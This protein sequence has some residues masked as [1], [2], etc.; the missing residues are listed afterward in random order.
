MTQNSGDSGVDHYVQRMDLGA[1]PFN[2]SNDYVYAGAGRSQT[3][4]QLIHFVRFGEQVV[5]LL[6]ATGSGTSTLLDQS[7][8]TLEDLMDCCFINGDDE[9]SPDQVMASL[10]EQ[11]QLR[12][13]EPIVRAEFLDAIKAFSIVD[14]EP[15]PFLV[16]VDQAH[17]LSVESLSLLREIRVASGNTARLFLAGEYQLEQLAKLASFGPGQL[18]ILELERLS[19]SE[20]AEYLLGK[21]QSVG[22]AGD[23]PLNSD[24]LAVLHEQSAGNLRKINQLAPV[25]LVAPG[26]NSS[27]QNRFRIPIAHVAAIIIVGLVLGISWLF[28]SSDDEQHSDDPATVSIP[29]D[30]N[31]SRLKN[32]EASPALEPAPKE[33]PVAIVQQ[34]VDETKQ[35]ESVGIASGSGSIERRSPLVANALPAESDPVATSDSGKEEQQPAPSAVVA[36]ESKSKSKSKS[37][38]KPKPKPKPVLSALS[39]REH[40]ILNLPNTAYMLQL[41]GAIDEART[42]GL[43]KQYVGRLPV[44]YFATLRKN[45]PWFVAVSGPYDSKEAALTAI[46]FLPPELQKERPWARSVAG[47]QQEIRDSRL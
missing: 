41:M 34:G 11:L 14:G 35:V 30:L 31:K 29:L 25:L 2:D 16:A 10:K 27:N 39:S 46:K 23:M 20:T 28:Q 37:K 13:P 44:T 12:L 21:L 18:K 40:R 26:E 24:Q 42:R 3:V 43:V 36:V 32:N 4:D 17:F 22:Y 1:D 8:V 33:A 5:M 9:S 6:G 7:L 45:K 19:E 47:L 38:P 15:E